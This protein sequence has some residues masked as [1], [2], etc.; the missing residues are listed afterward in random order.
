MEFYYTTYFKHIISNY[1]TFQFSHGAKN[2]R[3]N[4]FFSDRICLNQSELKGGLCTSR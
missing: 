3:L 1:I 4:I 2:H